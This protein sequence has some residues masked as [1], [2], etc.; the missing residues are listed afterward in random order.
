M[1]LY[2]ERQPFSK[3]M[4]GDEYDPYK[5][6]DFDKLMIA[7]K[8]KKEERKRKRLKSIQ[9]RMLSSEQQQ[10]IQTDIQYN[11]TSNKSS[12]IELDISGEEAYQKRTKIMFKSTL[13]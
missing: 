10:D 13:E 1:G 6:N 2:D 11:E 4:H 3:Y 5:P 7:Y 8:K 12:T 9:S